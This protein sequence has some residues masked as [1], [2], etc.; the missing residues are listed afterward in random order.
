MKKKYF[1]NEEKKLARKLEAKKYYDKFRKIPLTEEE[2]KT[3]KQEKKEN[4][5]LYLKEY[6]K[7]NKEKIL[8]Y[9]KK[10]FK[11]NQIEKQKKNNE[12]YNKR[13]SV[14]PVFKLSGNIRRGIIGALKKKG[15]SKRCRTYEILGCSYQELKLHL[16]TKFELWMN[17]DNYG[18]YNGDV[19]FGWDI[20]H[21][22]PLSSAKTEEEIIGLNHY[23]NLRPLCSYVNRV[24]KRDNVL[25]VVKNSS[26]ISS[27]KLN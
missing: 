5:K 25:T 4:K 10:Y 11:D 1:T 13:R 9:S 2:K 24:V 22:I 27:I 23:T 7:K 3:L 6:Y 19:N 17:W 14:D 15:F 16:E 21:I 26:N 12:R 8:K 18:L 20:D